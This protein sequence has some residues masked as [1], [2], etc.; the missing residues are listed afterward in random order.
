MPVPPLVIRWAGPDVRRCSQ[1]RNRAAWTRAA[2]DLVLGTLCRRCRRHRWSTAEF[3]AKFRNR[4]ATTSFFWGA[5]TTHQFS[6]T[7][8]AQRRCVKLSTQPSCTASLQLIGPICNMD[9]WDIHT[10]TKPQDSRQGIGVVAP[11][12]YRRRVELD[13]QRV[14]ARPADCG[15][16]PVSVV[17]VGYISKCI[18]SARRSLALPIRVLVM[19]QSLFLITNLSSPPLQS[20][21]NVFTNILDF[22][23][24]PRDHRTN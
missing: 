17:E 21:S 3:C 11:G 24:K 15:G 12:T 22:I 10:R 8:G 7:N 13:S 6:D 20:S 2:G 19:G 5:R 1:K 9:S 16:H 4:R 18:V 23:L 14:C